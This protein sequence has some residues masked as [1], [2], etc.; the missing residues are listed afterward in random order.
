MIKKATYDT[1]KHLAALN[2]L[3]ET[4]GDTRTLPS[5]LV[6]GLLSFAGEAFV[7]LS[8]EAAKR[9][10]AGEH[11]SICKAM[12]PYLEESLGLVADELLKG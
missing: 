10:A 5:E 9:E 2:H 12:L 7:R 3:V 4:A 1:D 11:T 6:Y 8:L